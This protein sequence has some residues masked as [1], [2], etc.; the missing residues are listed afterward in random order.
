MNVVVAS[1]FLASF[2]IRNMLFVS[3]P[4][5]DSIIR[6]SVRKAMPFCDRHSVFPIEYLSAQY[7]LLSQD[8]DPSHENARLRNAAL[9]PRPAFAIQSGKRYSLVILSPLSA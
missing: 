7:P 3:M 1:F 6:M 4:N 5:S 8:M 2:W 9:I